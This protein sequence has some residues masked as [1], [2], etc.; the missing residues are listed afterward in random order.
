[1]QTALRFPP[2]LLLRAQGRG[3]GMKAAIFDVDGVLT[4]GRSTSASR[5]K[6]SRP[7]TLDGH[8][9]KLLARRHRARRH[10]RARLAG[11]AP[12]RGRPGHRARALRRATT[13]WPRPG[14]CCR[15]WAGWSRWRPW[16]TTGPTCR[17]WRA[18]AWPARRPMRMPRCGH[19][20]PRHG[21]AG[22][23][24]AAR[25]FCDLLL[26]HCSTATCPRSTAAEARA[27]ARAWRSLDT[28]IQ[29]LDPLPAAAAQAAPP[30]PH[31]GGASASCCR[32]TCRW[33]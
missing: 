6:P 5:A 11:G 28:L 20:P 7:S 16:A 32:P 3:L 33:C 19:R 13:S 21:R 15:N 23:H 17:C 14:R 8:G 12:A 18:P 31:C 2:E 24:G 10:H 25:E 27:P 29:P 4:D 1:M 22:G 30:R 26:A 9:L